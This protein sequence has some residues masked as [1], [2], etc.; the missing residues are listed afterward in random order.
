M[1]EYHPIGAKLRS[2]R[3]KKRMTLKALSEQTGLS[4]AYLS[5]LENDHCSP[6]LKNIE[7]LC[8]VLGTTLWELL[9]RASVDPFIVRKD[10]RMVVLDQNGALR[11]NMINFE[12]TE[13][14]YTYAT[15]PP[16]TPYSGYMWKNQFDEVGTILQG[17]LSVK[18]WDS[19]YELG[20]GD[21]I[22]IK[23]QEMHS[24]YND[25][26]EACISYWVQHKSELI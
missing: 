13:N 21:T 9:S 15:F 18:L 23:A 2:L 1:I 8:N 20:V 5:N 19:V 25:R 12:N 22:M 14:V 11:L 6:T 10:E 7:K 3:K 24:L 4:V 17:V 16:N 26:D